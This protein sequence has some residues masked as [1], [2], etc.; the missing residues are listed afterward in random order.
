[1]GL[2]GWFFSIGGLMDGQ[3]ENGRDFSFFLSIAKA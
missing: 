3:G 2:F 1:M